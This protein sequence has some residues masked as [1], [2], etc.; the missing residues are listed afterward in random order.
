MKNVMLSIL[1]IIFVLGCSKPTNEEI[2]S[3]VDEEMSI[4]LNLMKSPVIVITDP[5]IYWFDN[6]YGFYVKDGTGKIYVF[7]HVMWVCKKGDKLK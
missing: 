2:M 7:K 1:F 5:V 3:N 6:T 4:R